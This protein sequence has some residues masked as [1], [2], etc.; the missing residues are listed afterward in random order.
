MEL[1]TPDK[2]SIRILVV[3]DERTLRESCASI[4]SGEGYEVSVC[5]TG[6]ETL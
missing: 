5:G 3:D 6:D 1:Q 4:L 2:E